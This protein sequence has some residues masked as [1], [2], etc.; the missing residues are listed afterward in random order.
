[1]EFKESISNFAEQPITKQLLLSLLKDYK[2]PYDKITELVKQG[3]LTPLKRGIFIPGPTLNILKPETFL[4]ANHLLGPSYISLESALSYWGMIPERVFEISS[5]TIQSSRIFNTAAGRFSYTHLPLPYYSFGIQQVELTKKQRVMM[6]TP[7]KALCD[8]IITTSGI[9]LRSK[10]Q[11]MELLID[12]LRIDEQML[13]K[14][15]FKN[16]STWII[17]APKKNSLMLLIK[18]LENYD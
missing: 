15:N 4:V 12:D 10:K 17:N 11:V 2:R 8:K 7:E 14:L 1:M 16:I 5:V 18:T 9:L 3:V 13:Q 6:A